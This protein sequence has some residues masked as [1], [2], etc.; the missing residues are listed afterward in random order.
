VTYSVSPEQLD[1]ARRWV[2]GAIS[3][4]LSDGKAGDEAQCIGVLERLGLA[5]ELRRVR[6]RAPFSWAMPWGTIDPAESP[7]RPGSPIAP[8]WPDIVVASGRRTVAYLRRIAKESGG[9]TLTV[10]LK[11]PRTGVGA[12][13]VI[14]VPEHDRLRGPNVLA[15]LTSPHR[16]SPERLEAARRAPPGWLASSKPIVGVVLGGDSRHH[17]FAPADIERLTETL[18]ALAGGGATLVVT[19]SR[20][21]PMA[22]AAAVKAICAASGGFFWD[23][24]GQNPYLAILAHA[25]H[26]VVTADSVNMVGEAAA[27]GA[28]IHL[29]TPSGG[30][31]KISSF[32][33][34]LQRYGAV[35]PLTKRLESWTYEPLDATPT[36]AVAVA[37]A[38]RARRG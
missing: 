13:D 29:F 9:R 25:D 22:L 7:D 17:R 38:Y 5:P 12:A 6:P 26:L 31:R 36:V 37:K 20:R 34:G 10:V 27:T 11:D 23:G 19:P 8:P 30:H 24:S 21:T 32:L 3:W 33:D 15:T 2:A 18:E 35:R 28:P 16:I 4:V 1:E 14:W